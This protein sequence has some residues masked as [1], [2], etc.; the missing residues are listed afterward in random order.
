MA[1]KRTPLFIVGNHG[2]HVVVNQDY[3]VPW[4]ATGYTNTTPAYAAAFG[5]SLGKVDIS[6]RDA[7]DQVFAADDDDNTT[8][9][10]SYQEDVI[11]PQ[12]YSM[13]ILSTQ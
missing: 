9:K 4:H 1:T 8:T 10:L 3:H 11:V 12:A 5:M 13:S 2:Y 6:K 7:W